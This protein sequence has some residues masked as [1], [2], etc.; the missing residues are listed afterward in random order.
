[1]AKRRQ[2]MALF[3]G[4]LSTTLLLGG[5]LGNPPSR[6]GGTAT[7]PGGGSAPSPA[8]VAN[9]DVEVKTINLGFI[10]ILEAA[11]L[12]IGVEKGFFAKHEIGRAH[13]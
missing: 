1:M 10:P 13:V 2:F 12:V 7:A 9:A 11:P 8:P 5:C 6:T 4:A 3:S